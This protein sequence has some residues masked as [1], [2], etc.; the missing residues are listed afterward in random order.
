MEHAAFGVEPAGELVGAGWGIG[1]A[2]LQEVEER[3]AA[4]GRNAGIVDQLGLVS[5]SRP[6]SRSNARHKV[7]HE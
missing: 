5:K 4:A 1:L 7:K 2:V 6:E 3:V